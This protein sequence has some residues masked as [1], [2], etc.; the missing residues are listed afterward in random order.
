MSE[1]LRSILCGEDHWHW[2]TDNANTIKFNEDGTGEL[3][4]FIAAE[5][6]WEPKNPTSLGGIGGTRRNPHPISQFGIEMTL[7]KRAT[8]R[9]REPQWRGW[10]INELLITDGAFLPKACT[11]KLEKGN[12]LTPYTIDYIISGEGP[13]TPHYAIRL[14]FDKSPYP[15]R[16]EWKEPTGAPDSL[17]M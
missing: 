1:N 3:N 7:A 9:M 16:Q 8:P 5:F 10:L 17:K 14:A 11:V 6:A 13:Y 4:I 12:F 2:D 15:P